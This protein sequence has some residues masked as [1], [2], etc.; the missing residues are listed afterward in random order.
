MALS[1]YTGFKKTVQKQHQ[2]KHTRTCWEVVTSDVKNPYIIWPLPSTLFYHPP[3]DLLNSGCT[4]LHALPGAYQVC[5]QGLQSYCFL[6][7]DALP[8]D[9][10]VAYF[11]TSFSSLLKYHLL[12][13][14]FLLNRSLC[15]WF[16]WSF[17]F[18]HR[19]YYCYYWCIFITIHLALPH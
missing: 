8:P 12:G 9:T 15:V 3:S 19:I 1:L 14:A 4:S 18:L 7:K 16:P 6:F 2:V 10:H 13:K 17:F 5:P 11:L